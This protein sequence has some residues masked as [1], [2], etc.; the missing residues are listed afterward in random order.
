MT[1]QELDKIRFNARMDSL[2]EN[3]IARN[4]LSPEF[5]AEYVKAADLYRRV[6]DHDARLASEIL[7]SSMMLCYHFAVASTAKVFEK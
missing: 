1:N 5:R 3:V 4:L 2:V 7:F 6:A